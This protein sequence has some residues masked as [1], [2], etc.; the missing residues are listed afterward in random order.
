MLGGVLIAWTGNNIKS[1]RGGVCVWGGGG[2][3]GGG[4]EGRVT[5]LVIMSN[6]H[7]WW[8]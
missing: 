5:K 1:E 4:E 7:L 2:G 8:C 3:G 6:W